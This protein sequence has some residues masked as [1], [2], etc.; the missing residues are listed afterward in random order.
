MAS[1]LLIA[2]SK[3]EICPLAGYASRLGLI[4]G[5]TG[6]GKAVTLQRIDIKGDLF[7]LGKRR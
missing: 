7:F 6:R 3:T 1:L 2:E 4:A 5:S